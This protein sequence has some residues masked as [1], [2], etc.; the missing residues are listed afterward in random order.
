MR[1]FTQFSAELPIIDRTRVTRPIER[2][3]MRTISGCINALLG[4]GIDLNSASAEEIAGAV[5][6][7]SDKRMSDLIEHRP[8]TSWDEVKEIPG[9]DEGMVENMQAAGVI[10]T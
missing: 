9:F 10:I 2:Y 5:P 3:C 6:Q 8:F 1:L 4:M 7:I